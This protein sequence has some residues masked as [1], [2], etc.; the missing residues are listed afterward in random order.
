LLVDFPNVEIAIAHQ[1]GSN[2]KR[3]RACLW[4]LKRARVRGYRSEEIFRN[5]V[6][7]RQ[8]LA[9]DQPENDF[10]RCG[11]VWINDHQ[12]SVAWIR[13]V[14]V[15]IDPD[16]RRPNSGERRAQPVLNC[17]V[18]RDSNVHMLGGCR[19]LHQQFRAGKERIL[20]QHAFFVPNPH[21][22]TKFLE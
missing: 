19:R 4:I 5:V 20:F 17:G 1:P 21:G 14:M 6:I 16:F 18:E 2:F 10:S 11:R 9:L 12:V 22:F 15:D 7:E 3:A 13:D 8:A